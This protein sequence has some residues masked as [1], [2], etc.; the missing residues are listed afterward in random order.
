MPFITFILLYWIG[1]YEGPQTFI[2][3]CNGDC[4]MCKPIYMITQ[5]D[6]RNNI[7]RIK[8]ILPSPSLIF[9]L[10]TGGFLGN[11]QQE[12]ENCTCISQNIKPFL[13]WMKKSFFVCFYRIFENCW[14]LQMNYLVLKKYSPTALTNEVMATSQKS[15]QSCKC[16]LYV[17][18]NN[19]KSFCQLYYCDS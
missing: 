13:L 5:H 16:S 6:P 3:L 12:S 4:L 14:N 11:S 19:P 18:M 10:Q 9:N 7:L 8:L 15:C 17:W 2:S 1:L